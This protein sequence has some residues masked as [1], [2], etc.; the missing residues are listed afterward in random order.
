MPQPEKPERRRTQPKQIDIHGCRKRGKVATSDIEAEDVGIVDLELD[1]PPSSNLESNHVSASSNQESNLESNVSET[2]SP[3]CN[4]ES[5]HVWLNVYDINGVT[6]TFNDA[7]LQKFELCLYHCGVEVTG[8]EFSFG[9]SNLPSGF[10][11]PGI[12]RCKPRE[13]PRFT[14]KES[15]YMGQTE[16]GKCQ[17]DKL[18]RKFQMDWRTDT[19]HPTRRNCFTFAD[20][21]LEALGASSEG[22][23]S[24]IPS[25]IRKAYDVCSNS[26]VLSFIAVNSMGAATWVRTQRAKKCVFAVNVDDDEVRVDSQ[27]PSLDPVIC[28]VQ[29]KQVSTSTSLFPA[30]KEG[31]SLANIMATCDRKGGLK[32]SRE[33]QLTKP[34][35]TN[36]DKLP[37]SKPLCKQT[38][39]GTSESD[40]FELNVG[41]LQAVIDD[42]KRLNLTRLASSDS[43]ALK[44]ADDGHSSHPEHPTSDSPHRELTNNHCAPT[45]V[46]IGDLSFLAMGSLDGSEDCKTQSVQ[47]SL[48]RVQQ[49]EYDHVKQMLNAERYYSLAAGS[50]DGSELFVFAR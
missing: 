42:L 26:S 7:F 30:P 34:D 11:R 13:A 19:F 40:D 1:S 33:S 49:L 43:P 41:Q 27:V 36:H 12:S 39:A 14:F 6:S 10:S 2:V 20:A 32:K 38:F 25:R 31:T 9:Q 44:W 23:S 18:I 16:K 37:V 28:L 24:E 48:Q 50:L 15:I 45:L 29:N 22:I 21:F 17:V 4:Q 35:P 47:Q 3:S 8:K 46:H 5:N